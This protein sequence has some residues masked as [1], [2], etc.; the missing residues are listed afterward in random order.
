V[1]YEP[2]GYQLYLSLAHVRTPVEAELRKLGLAL[3]QFACMRTLSASPGLSG[4]ELARAANVSPQAMDRVLA[5]LQNR[6][7]VTRSTDGVIGRGM[8]ARLTP[9]GVAIVRTAQDAVRAVDERLT[10]G[11]TDVEVQE[12]T[13]LLGAIRTRSRPAP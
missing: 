1:T 10:A 6:G 13:R 11:L 5:D 3:P 8:P 4:A 9:A 12:L 7:L 2:L